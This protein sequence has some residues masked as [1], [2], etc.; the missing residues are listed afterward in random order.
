MEEDEEQESK[1]CDG[2]I[3]GTS[4]PERALTQH[5]IAESTT[6]HGS[7]HAHD[8]GTKPVE[9][10]SRSKTNA[11]DG[12]GEGAKIIDDIDETDIHGDDGRKKEVSEI[13]C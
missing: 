10:L 13:I 5:D 7:G 2:E 3:D 9:L 1:A 11:T 8:E 12:K 6:T 4:H